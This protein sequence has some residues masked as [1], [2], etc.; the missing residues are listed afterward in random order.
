MQPNGEMTTLSRLKGWLSTLSFRTGV[1]VAGVCLLCYLLSF[2]QMFLPLPVAVKG[3]LWALFFG[4]AKAAQYSA[5]LILG[6]SGLDK[7]RRVRFLK[8]QGGG[9][10]G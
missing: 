8:R 9:E 2:A 1:Y 6:K 7:L 3:G 5:L 10:T 4:L